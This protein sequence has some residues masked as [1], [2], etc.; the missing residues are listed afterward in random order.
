MKDPLETDERVEAR[1]GLVG[2]AAVLLAV[3][4]ILVA[5]PSA[6]VTVGIVVGIV[7]TI[8][9][10]ELGHFVAAKRA[11]MKVTELFLGFGPRL[12]SVRRGE[13]EYGV[14]AIPAGGYVRIV[15]MHNLEAVDPADEARSYRTSTVGRRLMVVL[16]GITV[17]VLL[18]LV[19]V[20]FALVAH[21]EERLSTT[22]GG[23]QSGSA[24]AGAG[25]RGGD[26]LVAVE[27][28]PI[29]SW[30][31]LGDHVRPHAG[32][33]LTL[34]VERDRARL[35]VRAVPRLV[36]GVGRLGVTSKIVAVRYSAPGAA[37]ESVRLL[38]DA[39]AKTGQALWHIVSPSGV[40]RY[41]RT[42]TSPGSKGTI[43]D[44]E[45]PRSV[46]GIVA[47]G[48]TIVNG[49]VYALLGLLASIN[50]FVALFNAIPLPPF[51][52]GHAAVAIY[53][54]IAS[55][56]RRRQVT[57]DYRRLMPVAA[58]VF[59]LLLML[60]LSAMYLDVRDIVTR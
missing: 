2:A 43:S 50:L 21:G 11:G 39:T 57:V 34:T 24:A 14:K 49:D 44:A 48:G 53:E 8:M 29:R 5:R 38:G 47:E 59:V 9:L 32:Q 17:N 55:R 58:A 16:A 60:G 15:G 26:R 56:I 45:R 18:F 25:L 28:H 46:I 7:L 4:V 40:Q 37:V 10:H 54:G 19:L 23:V 52:G 27:G 30:T 6:W 33:P 41:S 42:V 1:R 35:R 3:A 31:D 51:D 12:W 22:I 20:L 36:D 13:T